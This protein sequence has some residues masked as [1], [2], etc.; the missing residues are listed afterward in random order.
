MATEHPDVH[1]RLAAFQSLLA[2]DTSASNSFV[3]HN[4]PGEASTYVRDT[5]VKSIEMDTPGKT[6]GWYDSN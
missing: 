2:F 1:T 4:I 5:V 3:R 6:L